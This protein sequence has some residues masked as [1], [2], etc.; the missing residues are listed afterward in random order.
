MTMAQVPGFQQIVDKFDLDK[1]ADLTADRLYVPAGLNRD[2]KVTDGIREK[3][4]ADAARQV[5]I[6][7]NIPA[8]AQAAKN[9]GVQVKQ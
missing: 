2:Q 3:R 9:M 1:Y 4:E 6:Q 8:M 7:E 5:Q